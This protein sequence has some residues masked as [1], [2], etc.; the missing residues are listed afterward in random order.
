VD[1]FWER[2]FAAMMG[3][4]AGALFAFGLAAWRQKSEEK[5][6]KIQKFK[7]ALFV[8]ILQRTF[9]R[10]LRAQQLEPKPDQ[11]NRAYA[12][13]AITSASPLESFDIEALAFLLATGEADLLNRLT[14]AEAKYRSVV[15]LG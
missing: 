11:P 6:A 12:I 4:A 7:T 2:A 3:S 15:A 10:N 13:L 5:L 9:L 1:F 14:V 8:L